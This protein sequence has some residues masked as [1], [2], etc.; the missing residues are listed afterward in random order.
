MKPPARKAPVSRNPQVVRGR[1]LEAARAE[2]MAHGFE[3]ASTNRIT[4]GFGGSKATLFRYY[5]TKERLL[6]AVVQSIA[7]QWE[8]ALD[9][10]GLPDD[11]PEDWLQAIG[12][13]T[14]GW[15]LRDEPLFVGRLAIAEGHRFPALERTFRDTATEP[16]RELIARQ[17]RAWTRRGLLASSD[18]RGD[19]E[20]FVDLV[21]GGLVSRRLYREP[22]P[23]G[24]R[25]V[26]HVRRC[27]T[28]FLRGCS[29]R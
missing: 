22:V 27:V 24:A 19:A 14:L 11:S 8:A 6:E 9:P 16:L 29:A 28:L 17:L 5:P 1:I 12:A 13:R 18:A 10:A 21:V 26:A 20:H 15:I 4:E 23:A 2:F 25:L 7:A 3:S